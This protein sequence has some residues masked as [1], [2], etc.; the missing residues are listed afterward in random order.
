MLDEALLTLWG[1]TPELTQLVPVDRV[2]TEIIQDDEGLSD[3]DDADWILDDCVTY[4]IDTE[5]LYRSNSGTGYRSDVTF[6]AF[7]VQY[8]DCK[9]IQ[10]QIRDSFDRLPKFDGHV[11]RITTCLVNEGTVEQDE[12]D[13]YWAASVNLLIN[14]TSA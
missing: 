4:E 10:E 6:T 3:D 5:V 13:G 2:S 12:A 8:E 11:C 14:H 7:S 9:K 1:R